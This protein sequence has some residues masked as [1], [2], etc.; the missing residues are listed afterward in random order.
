MSKESVAM[1]LAR[2]EQLLAAWEANSEDLGLIEEY[3]AELQELVQRVRELTSEQDALNARKQQV[4][5][6]LDTAKERGRDLALHV[7]MGIHAR[8]GRQSPKLV[9]FGLQPRKRKGSP[10]PGEPPPG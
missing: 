7:R 8:Y 5:R 9:E 4:T 3:R 6:A 2:W 1:T 10:P